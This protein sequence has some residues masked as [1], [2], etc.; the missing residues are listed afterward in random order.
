MEKEIILNVESL[1]KNFGKVRAVDNLSFN[2]F[3]GQFFALLGPNG[4]GKSTT[5]KILTTLLKQDSGEFSL[6]NQTDNQIIRNK[7]GV[8]FQENVLDDL[9]T[10]KENILTR[11]C[12]YIKNNSKLKKRYEQLKKDFFLEELE[13]KKFKNLSGGEKRRVEIARAL[14][15]EPKVLFLDEP[16]T[17]L[18]PESR[19]IVWK[20]INN[21]KKLNDLTII[22]TTHYMEETNDADYVLIIDSGKTVASGTP[23]ELKLKFAKDIFKIKPVDKKIFAE[24]LKKKEIEYSKIA[25]QFLISTNS[26]QDCIDILS[27]NK[28]NIGSFE[29]IKGSMDDVFINVLRK[30]K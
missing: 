5:I 20:I 24:N 28:D 10:V 6:E 9:L 22:L 19:K 21:L 7:I 18:D 29:M 17:G 15:A 25:D 30:K 14:L 23:T 4:A 8:V 16:T 26:P 11:G 1:S 13:N 12:L 3:R 2:V 27:Q